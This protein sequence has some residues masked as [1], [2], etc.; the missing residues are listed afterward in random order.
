MKIKTSKFK[1][2]I[3]IFILILWLVLSF[4]FLL[5]KINSHYGLFTE[6]E[7]FNFKSYENAQLSSLNL[8]NEGFNLIHIRDKGCFCNK[9]TEKH[10]NLINKENNSI[11]NLY[12]SKDNIE[13][14]LNI[15]IPATPM[16]LII[17]K[18]KILYAGAYSTGTT[19][20]IDNSLI[21]QFFDRNYVYYDTV[22][23]GEIRTCRCV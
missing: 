20:S 14:R 8:N 23:S 21:K 15:N 9:L 5:S 17:K 22:F 19:C 3:T 4:V 16:L 11:K 12:V 18:N 1:I 2:F 13:K 10:I 6:K 7:N